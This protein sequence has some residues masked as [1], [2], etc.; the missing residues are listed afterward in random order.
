MA[1]CP[2]CIVVEYSESRRAFK[3]HLGRLRE[4]GVY[5]RAWA[6]AGRPWPRKSCRPRST[7]G[8]RSRGDPKTAV[9][10]T[11]TTPVRSESNRKQG[12][13][14]KANESKRKNKAKASHFIRNISMLV[15]C[16]TLDASHSLQLLH[17]SAFNITRRT[18]CKRFR[19]NTHGTRVPTS[20][21]VFVYPLESWAGKKMC[22]G[23]S[24]TRMQIYSHGPHKT[25]VMRKKVEQRRNRRNKGGINTGKRQEKVIHTT[26]RCYV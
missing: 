21:S 26:Y 9:G 5:C 2:L 16:W 4:A 18:V 13:R 7:G 6:R 3:R 8:C 24:N 12:K 17:Q 11:P 1:S 22:K 25:E 15:P 10:P 20:F 14:R 23:C 19:P